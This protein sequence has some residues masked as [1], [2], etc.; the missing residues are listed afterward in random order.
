MGNCLQSVKENTE[1]RRRKDN[2]LKSVTNNNVKADK[3]ATR[4]VQQT[5]KGDNLNSSE[6]TETI[7]AG[8]G[9]L[10]PSDELQGTKPSQY[11]RNVGIIE[12]SR[13]PNWAR[14]LA[15]SREN[16]DSTGETSLQFGE[17][18]EPQL[19]DQRCSSHSFFRH[20]DGESIHSVSTTTKMFA[21]AKGNKFSWNNWQSD[22]SMNGRP[23]VKR[24]KIPRI[25]SSIL[26][27]SQLRQNVPDGLE[28]YRNGE[29]ESPQPEEQNFLIK[30]KQKH[31]KQ[32]EINGNNVDEEC[33]ATA[34]PEHKGENTHKEDC[35]SSGHRWTE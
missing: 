22:E 30:G 27:F 12:S 10:S 28:W 6:R 20:Q 18:W 14:L 35:T 21:A 23:T 32:D 8:D 29:A 34:L 11:H 31:S 5:Y 17:N 19:F 3:N 24:S 16:V 4:C 25:S 26:G 9:R 15:H 1:E 7:P 2:E 33:T 13:D